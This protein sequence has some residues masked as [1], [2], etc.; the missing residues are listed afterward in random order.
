MAVTDLGMERTSGGRCACAAV[1]FEFVGPPLAEVLCECP[2][3][4]ASP[5]NAYQAALVVRSDQFR[6]VTGRALV[7]TYTVSMDARYS[8][9]SA[10]G[11]ALPCEFVT[12]PYLWIPTTAMLRTGDS[13]DVTHG[14]PFASALAG[15]AG[16]RGTRRFDER[17]VVA[18]LPAERPSH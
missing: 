6:W 16:C 1:T 17:A 5:A 12:R 2:A 10:C 4:R 14:S 7:N 18:R 3:C 13:A 9:C 11:S 8:F 15:P